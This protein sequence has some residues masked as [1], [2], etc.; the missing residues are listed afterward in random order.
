MK[1]VLEVE[2]VSEEG[3]GIRSSALRDSYGALRSVMMWPS[4]IVVSGGQSKSGARK[5]VFGLFMAVMLTKAGPRTSEGCF[6]VSLREHG[7]VALVRLFEVGEASCMSS[8]SVQSS[9]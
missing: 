6:Y 7:E 3:T 2:I 4:L 5:Y 8:A 1:P 9:Q